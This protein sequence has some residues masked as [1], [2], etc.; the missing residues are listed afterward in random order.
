MDPRMNVIRRRLAD[1]KRIIAV[2]GGKGGIGKSTIAAALALNLSR[3]GKKVGLLDLDFWGPCAHIILGAKTSSFPK[4]HKGIVAPRVA[5]IR[6]MSIV[7]YTRN[8]TLAMRRAGFEQAAI[9]LLA[10]TQWGP[11]DVLIIDMPPGVGDAALDVVRAMERVEFCTVTTGSKVVLGT[12]GKTLDI[13][14][15]LGIPVLGVIQN[16]GRN[17]ASVRSH[18]RK[19][20]IPFLGEIGF[21]P[22]LEAAIGV[23]RKFLGTRLARQVNALIPAMCP[24]RAGKDLT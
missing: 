8:R 17:D 3:A 1:V 4:E 12:V 6:F 20:G 24:V 5:G 2:S 10:V 19:I 22:G 14:K 15:Q 9:E 16:M 13:L 23:P 7:Y 21:D 11:L 18:V